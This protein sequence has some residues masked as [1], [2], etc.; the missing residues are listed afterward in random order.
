MR[1]VCTYLLIGY[2]IFVAM[3]VLWMMVAPGFTSAF[4]LAA[5]GMPWGGFS[6]LV[7][8]RLN[9]FID[10]LFDSNPQEAAAITIIVC[11]ANALINAAIIF[12]ISRLFKKSN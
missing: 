12:G 4:L 7:F 10:A 3:A 8:P 5:A 11:I 9:A 1:R 6:M 2:L